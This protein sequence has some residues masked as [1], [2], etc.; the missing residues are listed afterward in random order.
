MTSAR[1]ARLLELSEKDFASALEAM[2]DE[3]LFSTMKDLEEA[4]EAQVGGGRSVEETATFSRTVLTENEIERRFPGQLLA[5][6]REW[7]KR[8]DTL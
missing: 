2:I 1:M 7:R 3:E 4:S 5:P 6:Y 8:R